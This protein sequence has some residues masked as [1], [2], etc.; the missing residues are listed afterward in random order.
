M[1]TFK[2]KHVFVVLC[3]G[4]TM[5][6]FTCECKN[7]PVAQQFDEFAMYMCEAGYPNN[8]SNLGISGVEKNKKYP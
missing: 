3:M 7:N 8:W 5:I 6:K 1:T 2:A 4:H